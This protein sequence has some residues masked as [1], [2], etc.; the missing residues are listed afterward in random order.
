MVSSGLRENG[1]LQTTASDE[2]ITVFVLCFGF[3]VVEKGF[4]VLF[5][6]NGIMCWVLVLSFGGVAG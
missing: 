4:D 2:A 1:K 5:V 6:C 3:E